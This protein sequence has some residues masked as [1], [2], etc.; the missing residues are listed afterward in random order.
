MRKIPA[1]H[2]HWLIKE[3]PLLENEGVLDTTSRQRLESYYDSQPTAQSN[4]I[5]VA[6]AILGAL[7]IG[8]G[9]ILLFAHNW[10]ELG[11]STRAVLS[12]C[13]LI[14]GIAFSSFALN[15]DGTGLKEAAAIFQTLA[16][17]ASIALI[18]QTYHI[19][20]NTPAFILTWALLSM[21]LIFLLRSV[22]VYI[23]YLAL[24]CFWT[25]HAQD[26]YDQAIGFWPLLLPALAWCFQC[27]RNSWTA[28]RTLI[29]L[30]AL[31]LSLPIALGISLE[32]KFPGLWIV[33]YASYFGLIGLLGLR[34]YPNCHG[35]SNPLG[36]MG[37]LGIAGLT[38]IFTWQDLWDEVARD[39]TH[40]SYTFEWGLWYDS[41]ITLALLIPWAM[42]VVKSFNR[43][44]LPKITLASF[45]PLA[46]LSLSIAIV[47]DQSLVSTL[48]FN[49]YMLALGLAYLVQGCRSIQLRLVNFGML[50]LSLLL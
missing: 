26:R 11:R 27:S 36:S 31:M 30:W 16:V 49:L 23:L 37:I 18:G 3:L 45:T 32:H 22:G 21:P 40:W 48:L 2:R 42:I 13:P 4:W 6:F 17:G 34:F 5:I 19:P 33:T 12:F 15:R 1:K 35:W 10:E 20:S 9:I 29:S 39:Y 50:I 24:I 14:V 8:G 43:H 38:Y 28:P 7:L 25:G 46:A 41:T 44:S 47:S